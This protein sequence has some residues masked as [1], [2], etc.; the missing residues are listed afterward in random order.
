MRTEQTGTDGTEES[1]GSARDSAFFD[2]WYTE[3][4]VSPVRDTIVA[5]CLGA[6]DEYV[7]TTGV[8]VW[9]ALDEI[10]AGLRLEPGAVLADVACGRGGYGIELARRCEGRL[11]G[12]DFSA[13][14]LKL[15][16]M[17]AGQHL[18]DGRA[19]FSLGL[20]TA[21]NLAENSVDALICTDAVQF[22]EPASAALAEF[23]RVL[24]SGGRLAL[25]PWKPIRPNPR[26]PE[27]LRS[28]D[29]R[30]DLAR[31]GFS[32]IVVARR[33]RWRAAERAMF[34]EAMA[35]PPDADNPVLAALQYEAKRSLEEFDSLQRIIVF[36]T[37]P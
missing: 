12:V 36:A 34:E 4:Q 25:T 29:L 24:K 21:T 5:R 20:L 22:A 15:A 19:D 3:L 18:E 6:P 9:E 35:T 7:G 28:L 2:R 31:L 37:A 33:E 26:L 8:L 32:E 13:V 23:G 17:A 16:E 27:S 10:A 1:I 30:G 11:Y 14:A